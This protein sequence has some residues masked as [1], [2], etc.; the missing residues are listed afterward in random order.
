MGPPI[1]KESNNSLLIIT[2]LPV[3]AFAKVS[4]LY[5]YLQKAA[6]TS[7]GNGYEFFTGITP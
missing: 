3:I 6:F 1:T 7:G 2:S 4:S 5:A